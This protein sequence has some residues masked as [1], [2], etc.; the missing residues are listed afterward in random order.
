MTRS[1]T[2]AGGMGIAVEYEPVEGETEPVAPAGAG[3]QPLK[4]EPPLLIRL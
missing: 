2:G 3:A 4:V 1:A